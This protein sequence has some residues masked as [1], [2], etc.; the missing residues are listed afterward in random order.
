MAPGRES[1]GRGSGDS[2]RRLPRTRQPDPGHAPPLSP[3]SRLPPA[4]QPHH[5]TLEAV[6]GSRILRRAGSARP[7]R[8]LQPETS[9]CFSLLP[10]GSERGSYGGRRDPYFLLLASLPLPDPPG[11]LALIR[12]GLPDFPS[13]TERKWRINSRRHR[14][15]RILILCWVLRCYKGKTQLPGYTTNLLCDFGQITEPR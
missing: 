12:R 13:L 15:S 11:P 4:T 5:L 14:L 1:A 8:L 9:L 6:G 2:G 3:H 7:R 10:W